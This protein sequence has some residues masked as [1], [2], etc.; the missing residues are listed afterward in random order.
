MGDG[1]VTMVGFSATGRNGRLP[2]MTTNVVPL[3]ALTGILVP[4]PISCAICHDLF[5]S[6]TQKAEHL[7]QAHPNWALALMGAYLRQTPRE[8]G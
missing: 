2:C 8:N 3:A 4:E 7:E 5:A 6:E 1:L